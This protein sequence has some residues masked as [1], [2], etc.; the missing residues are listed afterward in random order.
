MKHILFSFLLIIFFIA[1]YK[2]AFASASDSTNR[3]VGIVAGYR[4]IIKNTPGLSLGIEKTYLQSTKY[5]VIGSATLLMNR[6]SDVFTSVGLN[7]GSTLRR[8]GKRGVYL[9]HSLNI[10]Y[11][12]NYYDYDVYRTNSDGDILNVGRKWNSTIIMGYLIGMGYD[13]SIKT[14]TNL[15]LFFKPGIYYDLIN[16]TNY[17]FVNNYSIEIGLIIH[18]QWLNRNK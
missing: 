9:E 16:K 12:G 17:F 14:N 15:K 6:K 5:S 11:L 18:P 1:P 2:T 13:F 4:G 3:S 8:T 10:G 7:F